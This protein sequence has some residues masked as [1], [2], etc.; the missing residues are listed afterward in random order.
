MTW[1][2]LHLLIRVTK[3]VLWGGFLAYSLYVVIDFAFDPKW[4]NPFINPRATATR[5]IFGLPMAGVVL[6][7]L[8]LA[9]RDRIK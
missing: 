6:A 4:V 8:Q 3:W 9:V 5:I 2:N 7:L 1:A